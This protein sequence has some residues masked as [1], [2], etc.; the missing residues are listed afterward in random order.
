MGA[1]PLVR[2]GKLQKMVEDLEKSRGARKRQPKVYAKKRKH[3]DKLLSKGSLNTQSQLKAL[4]VLSR[5]AMRQFLKE[6]KVA[7]AGQKGKTGDRDGK[8][9]GKKKS[10]KYM[11]KLDKEELKRQKVT[12][13]IMEHNFGQVHKDHNSKKRGSGGGGG[14]KSHN[15]GGGQKKRRKGG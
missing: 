14:C 12:S 9:L 7:A 15:H 5:K 11:E 13:R 1:I 8:L 2:S 6:R 4:P 3:L 10:S